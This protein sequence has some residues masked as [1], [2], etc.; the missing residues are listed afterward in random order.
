MLAMEPQPAAPTAAAASPSAASDEALYLDFLKTGSRAALSE[1]VLRWHRPAYRIAQC[2]CL[3]AELAEEAVQ[4]A[5]LKLLDRKAGFRDGG[6]GSF[7]AW[8]MRIVANSTKMASRSERRAQRKKSVDAKDYSTRKN[9]TPVPDSTATR[10]ELRHSLERSLDAIEEQWRTP[11]VLH[12]IEGMQQKDVA[13]LLGVSQ[14][15]V[16]KRIEKGLSMLRVHLAQAG[17]TCTAPVL[18]GILGS[19]QLLLPPAGMETRVLDGALRQAART[20]ARE[21]ARAAALKSS[22]GAKVVGLGALAAGIAAV[23]VYSFQTPDAA[24]LASL[25]GPSAPSAVPA[26][27]AVPDSSA[28]WDFNAGIPKDLVHRVGPWNW[29]PSGSVNGSGTLR[30]DREEVA[31]SLPDTGHPE[32]VLRLVVRFNDDFEFRSFG[33]TPRWMVSS[34]GLVARYYRPIESAGIKNKP[35]VLEA[36]A[37]V[38]NRYLGY[39]VDGDPCLEIYFQ[40]PQEAVP[41]DLGFNVMYTCG[42]IDDVSVRPA[43]PEVAARWKQWQKEEIRYAIYK[44]FETRQFWKFGA[45]RVCTRGE[46]L[47][48]PGNGYQ[49][50]GAHHMVGGRG[51]PVILGSP[52]AVGPGVQI[53]RM[54]WRQAGDQPLQVPDIQAFTEPQKGLDDVAKVPRFSRNPLVSPLELPE[55]PQFE[56]EDR[57][58]LAAG[59][60]HDIAFLAGSAGVIGIADGRIISFWNDPRKLRDIGFA[61]LWVESDGYI[62]D[63][64]VYLDQRPQDQIVQALLAETRP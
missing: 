24:G 63:Y 38:E 30:A 60:W 5:F 44:D 39:T 31:F 27:P 46:I 8:F 37:S 56:S 16:S 54:R 15:M 9:I 11:V 25:E 45:S 61:F 14:Q 32:S 58:P 59:Q 21:S 26:E 64:R 41:Q 53:F 23:A 1:L 28:H 62:D 6:P 18:A 12:F 2:I 13:S 43:E 20:A 42:E 4:D 47:F 17:F 10:D 33:V 48:A 19:E 7:R 50:T 22:L 49:G 51:N 55:K 29:V 36:Y 35:V 52:C 3:N 34:K 57:T 40:D